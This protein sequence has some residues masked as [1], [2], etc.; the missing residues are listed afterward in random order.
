MKNI[1]N[2]NLGEFENFIKKDKIKK[3]FIISG[4]KSYVQSGAK[5]IIEKILKNKK[6]EYYFKT[7][8]LPEIKELKR[9]INH[10]DRFDPDLI[11]AIGGGS[12]IDY[13]KIANIVD[14]KKNLKDLI[15]NSRFLPFLIYIY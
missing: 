5:K 3:I 7:S 9:I 4:L 14:V 13:A 15:K 12:V 10:I 8:Y 2:S 6:K 11:L 1:I